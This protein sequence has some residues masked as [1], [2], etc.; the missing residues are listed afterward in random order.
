LF[1][2][3]INVGYELTNGIIKISANSDSIKFIAW[4]DSRDQIYR[5]MGFRVGTDSIFTTFQ[6]IHTATSLANI[7]VSSSIQIRFLNPTITSDSDI[8]F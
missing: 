8:Q 6:P 4:G 1:D 2:A 5:Y 3:G 7:A